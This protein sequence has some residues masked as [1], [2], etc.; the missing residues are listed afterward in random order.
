MAIVDAKC[1]LCGEKIL[2]DNQKEADICPYCK[3]AF[4]TEKAISLYG[5]ETEPVPVVKKRHILKS[6]GKGLL[7][8]AECIGYLIYVLC[9]VWLFVDITD[10]ITKKK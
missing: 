4:V 6:L 2:V 10:N 1:T 9:L 5:G 7:M 3:S 8:V